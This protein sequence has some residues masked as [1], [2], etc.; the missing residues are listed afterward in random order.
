[1]S[2]VALVERLRVH[3]Q[4]T[5]G[6]EVAQ[7][8]LERGGIHRDQTVEAIA[9][10]VDALAAELQLEAR[11]AEQSAGRRAN[12][13]REVRQGGEVVARPRDSVVNCSPVSCIPSPE[14]PA[15]RITARSSALR[16]F[17]TPVTGVAIWLI[18]S[19]LLARLAQ[20]CPVSL[21]R[22]IRYRG[23]PAGRQVTHRQ[24]NGHSIGRYAHGQDSRRVTR[25]APV[26]KL[27]NL[28]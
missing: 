10:R 14:S 15:K 27:Q 28:H 25:R 2:E 20:S 18:S 16:D 1:L 21:A 22:E 6:L 7:V 3:D 17:S 24:T 9:R 4:E 26:Q 19:S 23:K 8:N 11:D 12:L 5:A 13:R